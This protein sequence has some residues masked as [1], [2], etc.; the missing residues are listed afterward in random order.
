MKN[1]KLIILSIFIG[2][3]ASCEDTLDINSDP[4]ASTSADPNAI[5][6]F[7]F[8]QYSARKVTE[9]GTRISDVNQN[10][11][12]N[13]NSP[14][15]GVS[16]GTLTGNTW[17]MMY[18]QVLG[19]LSLV[20]RDAEL[21][22][23]TSN[24]VNAIATILSAYIFYELT[25]IWE[26]VPY[27]QALNGA[28]FPTPEFDSQETVLNGVVDLLNQGI[29]LID[30]RVTEGEFVLSSTS[31]L[32]Y[33]GDFDKWK[34]FANSLK[35]RTLMM[36]KNG[37]ANV[38]GE[39]NTTLGQPL[40]T[41]NDEAAYISYAGAAG[42]ENGYFTIVT[43]F[44]G[45]DNESQNVHG[46]GDP[47]DKLLN[48]S[49]DPRFDIWIARN[50]LD[51][52]GNQRFPDPSTSVLS[53]NV[54]R[55]SLPDVIMTPDEIDLYKA[56][57]ALEGFTAAGDAATN[58]KNGVKNAIEWWSNDIP[59]I[60]VAVVTPTDSK[61]SVPQAEIDAYVDGLATPTLNDVYNEQY[62]ASFLNPVL[63]WNHVRRN[64]IPVLEVPPGSDIST[65]LKRFTYPPDETDSNPNTPAN[66][67]T[68]VAMWF[69]GN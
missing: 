36:L 25:S 15:Q 22:G 61:A 62:L 32:F 26:E 63:S 1:I 20:R 59:N 65:I 44:F 29:S 47:I 14:A 66:L 51:A 4:L 39:I 64:K 7:T 35:L 5:L 34:I 54:I 23:P 55:P 38:D 11:S 42:A 45:P 68:D 69:E 24:N 53:N 52:P 37:G 9:L 33:G 28:E 13:F 43:A 56:Q 49:G 10:M 67:Q 41:S 58:Y 6:P 30:N 2:V 48:G 21:A 57:L 19:N 17:G 60:G 31:D 3:F 40:M 50:D 18:Q 16:S 46:P 12:D 8:V 27:T